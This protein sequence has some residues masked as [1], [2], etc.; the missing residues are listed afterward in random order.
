MYQTLQKNSLEYNKKQTLWIKR[1]RVFCKVGHQKI[2]S[3]QQEKYK[4]RGKRKIKEWVLSKKLDTGETKII[5]LENIGNEILVHGT[6]GEPRR[7][8]KPL[9]A[10]E[11]LEELLKNNWDL[12]IR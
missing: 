5:T 11:Y 2:K 6:C 12:K 3:L 8:L 7:Y 4:K 1:E 10:M 9:V